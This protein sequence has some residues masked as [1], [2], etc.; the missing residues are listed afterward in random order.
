MATVTPTPRA[1]QCA[2]DVPLSLSI[3]RHTASGAHLAI[4]LLLGVLEVSAPEQA[5]GAGALTFLRRHRDELARLRDLLE[6]AGVDR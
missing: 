4:A 3:D 2:G 5:R 6:P 1:Y